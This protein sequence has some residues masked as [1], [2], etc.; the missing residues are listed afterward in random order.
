MCNALLAQYLRLKDGK[1]V[2]IS[3]RS[4]ASNTTLR[5]SYKCL[6]DERL[7]YSLQVSPLWLA[8]WM[9]VWLLLI[10]MCVA[11]HQLHSSQGVDATFVCI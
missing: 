1:Q 9:G 11:H 3:L 2:L 4:T 10:A 6:I 7:F 5:I 8:L